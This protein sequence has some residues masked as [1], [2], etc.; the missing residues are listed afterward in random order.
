MKQLIYILILLSIN[1]SLYSQCEANFVVTANGSNYQFTDL[2]TTAD[3]DNVTSRL[4]RFGDGNT[5]TNENPIHT[6]TSLGQYEVIL[7]IATQSGC[8]SNDTMIVEVCSILLDFNLSSVCDADEEISLILEVTDESNVLDSVV[9]YLDD[10]PVSDTAIATLDGTLNYNIKVPGDGNQHFVRVESTPNAFCS[11]TIGFFVQ[12]CN[13]SCFLSDLNIDDG[14]QETHNIVLLENEFAPNNREINLGDRVRFIWLDDNHS[15]TSVDTISSDQW[16][17]GV[18]DSTFIFEI[19]PKIPGLKPFFSTP[20]V[21]NDIPYTGNLIANCP[22]TRGSIINISFLNA[23]VPSMGFH[24]GIDGVVLKDTAYQY[25]IIGITSVEFFLP[26]DGKTHQISI[27]DIEDESC[28]LEKTVK[29]ISCAGLFECSMNISAEILERCNED[30]L[31]MVGV[32]VSSLS[33]TDNGVELILDDTIV[34]D[35]IYFDNNQGSLSFPILGDGFIHKIEAMDL[36]DTS[37]RD[38]VVLLVNDCSAACSIDELEIGTGSNSTI[39]LGVSNT[40]IS[41]Q[42]LSISSGDDILWQ[43]TQDSLVGVR[44][45]A[46][47]GPNSWDSGLQTDGDIFV[48][49]ILTAGI[50]P[51][52]LYNADE[53]TLYNASVEVVAS[54]DENK[55]PVF[56]NFL[57]VNGSV[58]GYDIYVDDVRLDAGPFSYALDGNNRGVFQLEG[59]DQEHSIEIRDASEMACAAN[60][61]FVAPTCEIPPC[62]GLIELQIHDSCYND[63]TINFLATV[64][65]PEPTEQGFILRLNGELFDGFPFLYGEN[66]ET[67]FLGSLLA[68][69]TEYKFTYVDLND[70]NCLDTLVYQSPICVTDC[71]LRLI[72]AQLVDSLYLVENPNTPDS[73]V[74]CQD[75]FINIEVIFNE[76]YSDSDSFRIIVDGTLDNNIYPYKL[77]DGVNTIFVSVKGDDSFHNI[78]FLDHLDSMCTFSIDVYTPICFSPCNIE[79]SNIVIDSCVTEVGYYT[80][81][82]NP[83]TNKYDYQVFYDGDPINTINDSLKINFNNEADGLAHHILISDNEVP[84]CRDSISFTGAYC[85]DCPLDIQLILRD[86]CEVEDSIGYSFS[87]DPEMDSLDVIVSTEDSSFIINPQSMDFKFDI[88]LRGDSSKYQYI[89]TS[90]EDI[91]CSDT[92]DVQTID[93]TPI[94]CGADFSFSIEGLTITFIDSSTTSEPIVDQSWSINDIINIGNVS[95]FNYTVDSIGLY[96]ICHTIETDSCSGM[97]CIEILVGDPCTQVVPFFTFEEIAEGYQF[98]NMSTGNIDEYLYRFGDGIFSN[99]TDP[100]HVYPDTGTY[101]VCL[102]VRQDEFN[103]N[104]IFCDTIDVTLNS[105]QEIRL[106]KSVVLYPNPVASDRKSIDFS[107]ESTKEIQ[108]QNIAIYD[109]NGRETKGLSIIKMQQSRFRIKLYNQ[110]SPGIYYLSIRLDHGKMIIEKFIVY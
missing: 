103:C 23:A 100:F 40:S 67:Q 104:E 68:D 24:L 99:S 81:N 107:Y 43:W 71:N 106:D 36:T 108:E 85:L 13:A 79:I 52:Y 78:Q 21:D 62:G 105:N 74:G 48:S 33:P 38:E 31:V 54:C 72:S 69:S 20:D 50:H 3:D 91:F 84:L 25:D 96:D 60:S 17:S 97:K 46:T 82:L 7:Q 12:D 2:S 15:T 49:P 41:L 102:I 9:I 95:T 16:D 93:C 109:I 37:C 57:D 65:H 63:N 26:G 4:W 35:T 80:L 61:S 89:F 101:E 77:G 27:V 87:F 75:S 83:E 58:D 90:A 59:D 88:R 18:H 86:S 1:C 45:I 11:E 73:L 5:T 98:T 76:E 56:Y 29:A 53:D 64:S 6:Y 70:P 47:S 94:I 32:D 42:N 28:T 22:D 8:E 66:G 92:I 30:S 39:V 14:Y 34:V 19:T 51:Y 10:I 110:L 44:S 55:I